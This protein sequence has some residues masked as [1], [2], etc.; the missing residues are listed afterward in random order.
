MAFCYIKTG[1]YHYAIKYAAQVL[2]NDP[3]NVKALFRR[4]VAYTKIGE[5]ERALEDLA[6]ALEQAKDNN[7]IISI[8]KAI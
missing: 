3:G 7:E 2:D 6:D 5:V 4:G 1:Q 8:K